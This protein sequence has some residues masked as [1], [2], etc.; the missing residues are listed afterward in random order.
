MIAWCDRQE[1]IC[2]LRWGDTVNI[3]QRMESHGVAGKIQISDATKKLVHEY[4]EVCDP[5][6]KDIPRVEVA[7]WPIQLDSATKC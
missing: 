1:Q 6:E 3:A 4:F 5:V 2:L 7:Y